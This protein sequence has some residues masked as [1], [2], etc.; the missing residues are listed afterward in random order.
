ML[1]DWSQ[2]LSSRV[3][4]P[5]SVATSPAAHFFQTCLARDD[6]TVMFLEG[7]DFV[8]FFDYCVQVFYC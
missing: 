3:N 2:E 8:A 7:D 6:Y 4:A 5:P 1:R